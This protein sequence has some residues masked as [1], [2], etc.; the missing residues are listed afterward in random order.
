MLCKYSDLSFFLHTLNKN[1]AVFA[2]LFTFSYYF[3]AKETHK[4]TLK[5]K[6]NE[7]RNS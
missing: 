2:S 3:C 4:W 1:N 5:R 6:K 7:L